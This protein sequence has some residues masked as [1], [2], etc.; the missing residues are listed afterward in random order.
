[1][2][3]RKIIVDRGFVDMTACSPFNFDRPYRF[4]G[5]QLTGH[6]KWGTLGLAIWIIRRIFAIEDVV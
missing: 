3:T 1:M 2:G 5:L 6:S 4:N